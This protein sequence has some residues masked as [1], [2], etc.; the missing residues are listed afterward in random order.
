MQNFGSVNLKSSLN[1]QDS[2]DEIE[3]QERSPSKIRNKKKDLNQ[4][5]P[6]TLVASGS[7]ERFDAELSQKIEST[8]KM[9][10]S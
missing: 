3:M 4:G 6:A 5:P 10:Q 8:Y 1:K 2:D 9:E 7:V